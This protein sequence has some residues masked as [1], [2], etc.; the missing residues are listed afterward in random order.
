VPENA[1]INYFKRDFDLP[2]YITEVDGAGQVTGAGTTD[3]YRAYMTMKAAVQGGFIYGAFS[4][5]DGPHGRYVDHATVK[6]KAGH[7][8][9]EFTFHPDGTVKTG[10]TF[11]TEG[12][13]VGVINNP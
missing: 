13:R 2:L 6:D 7:T 1:A 3:A 5:G 9:G 4:Y 12:H 10:E 11:D 8:R